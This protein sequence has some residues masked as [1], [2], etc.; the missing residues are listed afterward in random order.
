MAEHNKLGN[1]GENAACDFL[2]SK[3]YQ[4]LERN[5][6]GERCEVD[7]IATDGDYLVFVEVK[8]RSS[9][10]WANPEDAVSQAKMNRIIHAANSYIEQNDIDLCPRFDVISIIA[11]RNNLEIEHIDDAFYPSIS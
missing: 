3:G 9:S 10:Y 1:R 2:Q 5:W 7:I 4:I 8:T 11:G 6:S